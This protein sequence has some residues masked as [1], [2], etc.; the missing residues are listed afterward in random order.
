V[1]VVVIS[2]CSEGRWRCTAADCDAEILCPGA[3]IHRTD[4]GDCNSTCDGLDSCNPDAPLR[5]GCGCPDGL[6]LHPD[7]RYLLISQCSFAVFSCVPFL[8]ITDIEPSIGSYRQASAHRRSQ[9]VHPQG[10]EKFFL[11]I[12][13]ATRQKWG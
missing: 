12:F 9:E 2:L 13:V 4:L 8:S 1:S 7:V 6:V 3:L 11:G 5:S 10:D